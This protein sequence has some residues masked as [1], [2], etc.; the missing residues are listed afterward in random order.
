MNKSVLF[1]LMIM[2]I[3]IGCGTSTKDLIDGTWTAT[4]G[5]QNGKIQGEANC[6]PFQEGVEF[7]DEN[8]A[9]IEVYE[10]D[11]KYELKDK[12]KEMVF[13]DTGPVQ[14]STNENSITTYHR[15]KIK[16]I[17]DDEIGLEGQSLAEGN[18]CVLERK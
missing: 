3:L 6:Y 7:K 4:S 9:Y 18:T 16:K 5:Y 12:G 1:T 8:T 15:Y 2:L 14:E 11:F 17:S 13:R 10:R